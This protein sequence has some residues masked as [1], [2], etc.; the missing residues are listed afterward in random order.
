MLRRVIAP[1]QM[2]PPPPG[3][4]IAQLHLD[5]DRR[6]FAGPEQD[7]V[8]CALLRMVWQRGAGAQELRGC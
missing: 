8:P 7:R 5:L 3:Q 4:D 2:V 1:L 6:P